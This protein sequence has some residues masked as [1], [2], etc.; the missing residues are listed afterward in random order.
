MKS[1]VPLLSG[2]PERFKK[3]SRAPVA[4]KRAKSGRKAT[5]AKKASSKF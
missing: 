4:L 1:G 5:S 2:P 3:A